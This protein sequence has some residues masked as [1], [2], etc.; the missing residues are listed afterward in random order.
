MIDIIINNNKCN[1]KQIFI[2]IFVL[3]KTIPIILNENSTIPINTEIIEL[4]LCFTIS[5]SLLASNLGYFRLMINP[6]TADKNIV[7]IV[8][9][10]ICITYVMVVSNLI[11]NNI[12]DIKKN[13]NSMM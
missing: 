9:I 13:G 1:V 5:V 12:S 8:S 10:N 2:F 6:I 11:I 3:K 4:I 7:T